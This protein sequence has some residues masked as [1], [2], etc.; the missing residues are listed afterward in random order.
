M[1]S[2]VIKILVLI[3]IAALTVSAAAATDPA[4]Y[5]SLFILG[6]G[7]RALGMGG[8]FTAVPGS[9]LSVYYNPA[10][11]GSLEYRELTLL[12]SKLYENTNYLFGSFSYP[13]L[14]I[15]T[16]SISG[17]RIGTDNV[18]FRDNLGKL[19]TYD[20]SDGQYW[21]SYGIDLYRWLA[22]GTNLK[23][24]NQTLG[25]TSTS[26]GSLDLGLQGNI[27]NTVFLGV[28]AQDILSGELKLGTRG[29][30]IPFNIKAGL[31]IKHDW[32]KVG[33]LLAADLDKTEDV[34]LKYH[35]GGELGIRN[36]FFVRGGYD[37]TEITFG[38]GLRYKLAQ[39]DYAYKAHSDLDGTHRIGVS[40][41]F[42]PTI[43]QQRSN[44]IAKLEA[45]EQEKIEGQRQQA[46][47]RLMSNADRFYDGQAWDSAAVYYNQVLAFDPENIQAINRLRELSEK[48]RN[49]AQAEIDTRAG[50]QAFENLRRSYINHADSLFDQQMYELAELEYNKVLELDSV[51]QHAKDRIQDI[52]SIYDQRFND[53][54]AQGQ[55]LL[56]QE[57]YAEAVVKF[58]EA[59]KLKPDNR[60]IRNRITFA[61][62]KLLVTQK[63]SDA[64]QLLDGGD[65]ASARILFLEILQLD[66]ESKVA[67]NYL[68]SM[69]PKEVVVPVS[70][71]DLR[72]DAEY[73]NL[74]IE[75]LRF[76]GENEY[77]KAIDN[78]EKVLE[79]Y[80]GS[81]D[82][83]ENLRQARSR[84]EKKR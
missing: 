20:Y 52:V 56:N 31:A 55:S 71:E 27:K 57:L 45:A 28:N 37:R 79:K 5:E 13:F 17:I 70:I 49:Q 14:G 29:E 18:I 84:L 19:G 3:L 81:E 53:L 75:G 11:L 58:T 74:Y 30:K 64:V 77:Q 35:F 54:V 16:F 76:F 82:T 44:R 7:G 6:A 72:A 61:K 36:T 63:L 23:F 12:G 40:F 26:T 66:P 68:Q 22:L 25:E 47:A 43:S 83:K 51:D 50:Q 4:G 69:E 39:F 41:F 62:N 78:W 15:G 59:Q 38:A 60:E 46:I 33:I 1:K 73:W 65:S 32:E 9:A 2:C 48:V 67:E 42:G 24:I 10:G 21:L 34:N 8:A 80:P